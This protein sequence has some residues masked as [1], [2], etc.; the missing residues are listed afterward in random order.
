[1]QEVTYGP[2]DWPPADEEVRAALEQAYRDGSWGRYEG[3]QG[4]A[5]AEELCDQF[6][7]AHALL[8]SSGTIGVEL[9]LRGLGVEAGD[10]VVLAGYDFPG[11][12]RAIEAVG[13]RPVLV[14]VDSETWCLDAKQLAKV[15][16]DAISAVIVSHLHGGLADMPRVMETA[17]QRGWHVVEDCCQQPGA[18]LGGRPV[19]SW[20]DA[21][22]LSF[23]GSKL[24][25]AGRGG[26][27][28]TDDPQV[29]QRMK[30]YADRGNQAFPL[31]E[32]QAAVLR[33]QLRKLE[34]RNRTRAKRVAEIRQA[35]SGLAY[36]LRPIAGQAGAQAAY[37]KLA[38]SFV[39]AET[40]PELREQLLVR[41]QAAKAPIDGGF[42]GFAS[43]GERRCRKHGGLSN[44][45]QLSQS[46]ILL[47]HPVL[48]AHEKAALQVALVLDDTIRQLVA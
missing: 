28:L 34:E 33:P 43:R 16:D 7:C 17:Q 32:L 5:L 13:A 39:P 6:G 37:Y 40:Q 8:C 3:P 22:V 46:T 20:G 18:S 24:L 41:L 31:S 38:W 23:G 10:E 12:F 21:S 15:E 11:N 42:R 2:F 29:L 35:T 14:D 48:L 26:S 30:I 25:T 1:M 36:F 4:T 45:R 44:S 19:G 27:V 9:A 47:H